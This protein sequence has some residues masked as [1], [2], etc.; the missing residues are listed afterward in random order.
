M[1]LKDGVVPN[2]VC[3]CFYHLSHLINSAYISCIRCVLVCVFVTTLD[4][5]VM[6]KKRKTPFQSHHVVEFGMRICER[7][8]GT[9]PVVVKL[10]F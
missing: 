1:N 3:W 7:S 10:I 8:A 4:A 9:S 2:F 5:D 6:A